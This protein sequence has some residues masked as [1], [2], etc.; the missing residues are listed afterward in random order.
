MVAH[1]RIA[2]VSLLE[3]LLLLMLL[4]SLSIY[5][6]EHYQQQLARLQLEQAARQLLMFLQRQQ[7][8]AFIENRQILLWAIEGERGCVG[9]QPHRH[10]GCR[11]ALAQFV[12][13]YPDIILKAQLKETAGFY[14]LRNSAQAGH[15]ELHNRIGEIKAIW[16]AQGRIR[17]CAQPH[18]V[19]SI[20]PC[21]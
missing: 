11:E 17:L 10:P 1:H 19:L 12:V 14:G 4:A 2:G 15:I 9:I 6:V 16:S 20:P 21:S 8:K 5:A 13:L 7:Q 18:R 3:M